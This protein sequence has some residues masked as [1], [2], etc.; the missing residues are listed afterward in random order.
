MATTARKATRRAPSK[1][2]KKAAK[3]TARTVLKLTAR[4]ALHASAGA[5]RSLADRAAATGSEA[6][7]AGMSKRPP[8]QVG[9]DVAV[10]LTVAWKEWMASASLPEGVHRIQDVERDGDQLLGTIDG[11]RPRDWA[12]EITDDREEQSFAWRSV[13]GSDCA[14]LVTFHRL[15]DRLTRI[16]LDL[17]VVATNPAEALAL[18]LGRAQ[19]R[20]ETDLRRFKAHVEFINPDVYEADVNRNGG[21]PDDDANGETERKPKKE[22]AGAGA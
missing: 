4:K 9:V 6:L 13:E 17:D 15:S 12:A 18:S 7:E 11:V 3:V 20:A 2:T 22:K 5:I 10:P 8:I 21:D 1:V 14:G 19:H 16:E